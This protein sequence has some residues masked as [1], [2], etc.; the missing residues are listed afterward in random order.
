MA[1]LCCGKPVAQVT[2]MKREHCSPECK[3]ERKRQLRRNPAP[4]NCQICCTPF[5]R[6]SNRQKVCAG[7]RDAKTKAYTRQYNDEN[8][9]EVRSKRR[10]AM[11]DARAKNPELFRARDRVWRANN[12]DAIR[13]RRTSPDARAKANAYVRKRYRQDPAYAVHMRMA[14]AVHQALRKKKAGRKWEALVGYSLSEL[15]RHLERQFLPDMSW[16]NM[17]EWH[18]DHII[19]KSSFQYES[20]QDPEFRACWALTN[21]RPLWSEDNQKKHAKRVLLV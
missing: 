16:G 21:L 18:I 2:R 15:V 12:A 9:D 17:G 19:P 3:A 7:C 20:D 8:A 5:E 6:T 4:P 13:Q 14:S 1:C 11:A 10:G